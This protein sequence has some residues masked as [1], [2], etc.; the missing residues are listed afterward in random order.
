M[1]CSGTGPPRLVR[2]HRS[3]VGEQVDVC[4]RLVQHALVRA[5]ERVLL[6][7]VGMLPWDEKED[8]EEGVAAS[9]HISICQSIHISICQK[10]YPVA[11]NRRSLNSLSLHLPC[12]PVVSTCKACKEATPKLC[13]SVEALLPSTIAGH[14]SRGS[15]VCTPRGTAS[16]QPAL[17]P[18]AF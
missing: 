6:M 10:A 14:T 11:A 3:L 5:G 1:D 8:T 4:V 17:L 9:I 12:Q 16:S 13:Y 2:V 7:W 18:R 15:G